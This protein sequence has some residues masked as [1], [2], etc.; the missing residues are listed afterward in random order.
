MAQDILSED[1][2][3]EAALA[4]LKARQSALDAGL[5]VPSFDEAT[6]KFYIDQNGHRFVAE[7]VDGQLVP[8]TKIQTIDAA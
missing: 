2:S 1:F 5:A 6:G 3:R 8:V 7:F 4:G